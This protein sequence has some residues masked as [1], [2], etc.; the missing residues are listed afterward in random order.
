MLVLGRRSTWQRPRQHRPSPATT[1]LTD[2]RSPRTPFPLSQCTVSAHSTPSMCTI[3]AHSTSRCT[4]SA[5]IASQSLHTLF[6]SHTINTT[7]H[8]TNQTI[9]ILHSPA[10]FLIHPRPTSSTSRDN[11]ASCHLLTSSS[12]FSPP[13]RPRVLVPGRAGLRML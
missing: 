2:P 11:S 1:R 3:S 4:V 9:L 8:H 7:P 6:S 13:R 5:H 10:S 12:D